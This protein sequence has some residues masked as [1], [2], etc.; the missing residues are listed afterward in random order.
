[1]DTPLKNLVDFI[2]PQ[3]WQYIAQVSDILGA[4]LGTLTVVFALVG[5]FR[6]DEIKRYLTRITYSDVGK[7]LAKNQQYELV[8]FT[9][10]R[11]EV[12]LLVIAQTQPAKIALIAT[13]GSKSEAEKIA[14]QAR[15]QNCDSKIFIIDDKDDPAEAKVTVAKAIRHWEGVDLAQ[16]AVDVTGGTTPMSIGAFMAAQQAAVTTIY[17]KSEYDPATQQIKPNSS[18]LIC[19]AAS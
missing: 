6:R 15:V 11:A 16:I 14:A 18:R 4:V 9:V 7:L 1:M 12:P 10:S 5:F 13:E 8:I 19:I 3:L 17:M 2:S